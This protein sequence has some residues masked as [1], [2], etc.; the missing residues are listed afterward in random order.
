MSKRLDS[1]L[2]QIIR[3][4]NDFL[5]IFAIGQ[6]SVPNNLRGRIRQSVIKNLNQ[7]LS[8]DD[9]V[10]LTHHDDHRLRDLVFDQIVVGCI[11]GVLKRH[12]GIHR[13]RVVFEWCVSG[14]F[15]IRRFEPSHKQ[16]NNRRQLD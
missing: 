9:A 13:Y 8:I 2:R 14:S 11:H 5:G 12:N 3:L 4:S 10:M 16:I 15:L 1:Q 6:F 7:R